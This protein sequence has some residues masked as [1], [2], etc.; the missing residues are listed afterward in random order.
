MTRYQLKLVEFSLTLSFNVKKRTEHVCTHFLTNTHSLN[1]N[2]ILLQG[3][4]PVCSCQ[5]DLLA[6]DTSPPTVRAQLTHTVS[7]SNSHLLPNR[8]QTLM[9]TKAELR[10]AGT[11]T[12]FLPKLGMTTKKLLNLTFCTKKPKRKREKTKLFE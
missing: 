9:R 2:V 12:A 4:P 5:Q 8:R 7:Q 10:T 1:S 11:L 3:F 6:T